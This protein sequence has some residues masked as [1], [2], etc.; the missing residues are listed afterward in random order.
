MSA[1]ALKRYECKWCK[2]TGRVASGAACVSCSG[3]GWYERSATLRGTSIFTIV[4]YSLLALVFFSMGRGNNGA[5]RI[6]PEG[7]SVSS[8]GM[9]I[10]RAAI[11]LR[12]PEEEGYNLLMLVG[13]LLVI[14]GILSIPARVFIFK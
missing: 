6:I 4:V 11:R 2:G 1:G 5:W 3:R 8:V 9:A 12:G 14:G 10:V 7:L 13:T